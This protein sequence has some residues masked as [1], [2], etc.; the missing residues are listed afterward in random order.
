MAPGASRA[1]AKSPRAG[2]RAHRPVRRRAGRAPY[3]RP[4][5]EGERDPDLRTPYLQ[6]S[7]GAALPATAASKLSP[8]A[9][10]FIVF[11]LFRTSPGWPY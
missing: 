1:I 7:L 2:P 9:A 3:T 10:V 11:R 6:Q 8:A 4:H 5:L